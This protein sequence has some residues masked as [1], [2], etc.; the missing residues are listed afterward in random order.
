MPAVVSAAWVMSWSAGGSEG[1]SMPFAFSA[2]RSIVRAWK[3]TLAPADIM[4]LNEY[5]RKHVADAQ[6]QHGAV[7]SSIN[8]GQLER[9][10]L[11]LTNLQTKPCYVRSPYSGTD[12]SAAPD[13]GKSAT[14][15]LSPSNALSPKTHE[16][17]CKSLVSSV[18]H[19]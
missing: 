3:Q 9:Q 10:E 19:W 8:P 7:S 5:I 13:C 1:R 4:V 18:P 17:P 2:P 15:N 16:V 12:P 6:Q 11:V 14:N